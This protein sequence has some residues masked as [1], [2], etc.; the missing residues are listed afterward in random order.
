VGILALVVLVLQS[1]RLGQPL[2]RG[3]AW[4]VPL[5]LL[6]FLGA[7][8]APDTQIHLLAATLLLLL[9]VVE[10]SHALAYRDDLTGLPTRRALRQAFHTLGA[11]Y[12]VAMVDVDHFKKFNDRHGHDVG[13][14][15]LK[16]VASRLAR[17]TGGGRAF[18]YGGEEFT[19]LFP[20]KTREDA[21]DHLERLREDV[22]RSRFTLRRFGRPRKKPGKKRKGKRRMQEPRQLAVT[23]SIGVAQ[24]GEA[25]RDADAV[26]KAADRALYRAKARG[27]NRVAT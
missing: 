23:V 26:I 18:R 22:A 15:V 16:M 9:S 13:D 25:A 12:T 11:T 21:M 1:V 20:G 24:R 7:P 17:V 10:T 3:M 2:E 8:T 27:R 6:A 5:L 14:Q 4:M 19:V